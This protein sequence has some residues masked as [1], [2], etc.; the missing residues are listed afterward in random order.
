MK[1]DDDLAELKELIKAEIHSLL[2][3]E[4]EEDDKELDE[5]S[6]AGAVAGYTLPLGMGYT[7]KK[8]VKVASM[9]WGKKK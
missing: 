5:F 9:P 6:G 3:S 2:K 1:K 4:Q 8:A 7:K